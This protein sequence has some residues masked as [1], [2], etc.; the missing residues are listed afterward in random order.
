VTYPS[1]FAVAYSYNSYG[2]Q[3]QLANSATGQVYWTADAR[4]AELHLTQQTAGNGVV[5]TQSFDPS[6]FVWDFLEA[7]LLPVP[8]VSLAPAS[9]RD[10]LTP[11]DTV[12]GQ[13]FGVA[14]HEVGHATFDI[15]FG[16]QEEAADKFCAA[17]GQ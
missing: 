3:S 7:Q 6:V 13:F 14:L 10:G 8:R 2:Y 16:H 17:P 4:G 12:I 11:Y 15:I 1:G 5:T 9:D